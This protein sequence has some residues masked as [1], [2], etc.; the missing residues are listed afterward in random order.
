MDKIRIRGGRP[1]HGTIPIGG[2]KNA[3]LPLMAASLLTDEPL[4]LTQPAA[5]RRHHHAVPSP[6]AARRLH[7]HARRRERARSAAMC[8]ELDGAAH[9]LH[10]RAL[11]SRAQDAR[12]G[13]GAGAAASRAAARRGC[14]CPA[15]APSARGRSICISRG[16]SGWA[17]TIELRRGLYRGAAP[18]RACIGAEIVFP[19][20]SVGA[21]ENLLMAATLAEGETVLVNA[22]REPEIADLAAL[23]QRDGRGDR[24]RRHRPHRASRG[25][26]RLHGADAHASSPTASRPAPI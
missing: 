16:W 7:H 22:A 1:L 26:K 2:A 4:V 17:P 24:R 8:C 10:H 23:P 20:V 6:G 19:I 11:R 25:V 5:S 14:R 3:A 13:A 21:T 12:L 15:A 18:R 9:R